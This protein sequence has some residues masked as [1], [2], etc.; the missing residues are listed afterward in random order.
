M[1]LAYLGTPDIAVTPLRALIAAGHE[2]VV[3]ITRPPA[4]RSRRGSPV[5]SPVHVFADEHSIPVRFRADDLVENGVDDGVELAVVVAY[6]RIIPAHVLERIPMVNIH[7]SLLPRWRGAAPVE[8]ALLAGDPT[9]GI[10]LMEVVEQL[11][12]GGIYRQVEVPIEPDQTAAMIRNELAEIGAQML[13]DTLATG[14]PPAQPQI[15]V[16]TYADKIGPHDL[17][18][19]WSGD[20]VIA[21]RQVRV[22]GAW[23]TF[24]GRRVG[25]IDA[26]IVDGSLRPLMVQ[27]E[28]RNAMSFDSWVRG[29][30]PSASEWFE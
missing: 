1:R 23:T 29:S 12:A 13:V 17:R 26:E 10:C 14:L 27:P 7:F 21:M 3:V 8:R 15:G 25:I 22:G 11:D 16:V 19:D 20:P 18:I 2:I 6:G 9:T 4:R 30:R 28:G 24:R 5:P